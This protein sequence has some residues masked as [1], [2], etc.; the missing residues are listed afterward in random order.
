MAIGS[1]L[2]VLAAASASEGYKREKMLK[3]AAAC[4]TMRCTTFIGH[5]ANINLHR[6]RA[7]EASTTQATHQ[8]LCASKQVSGGCPRTNR[9]LAGSQRSLQCCLQDKGPAA[10][11]QGCCSASC[12]QGQEERAHGVSEQCQPSAAFT[13][14]VGPSSPSVGSFAGLTLNVAR[15]PASVSILPHGLVV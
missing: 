8:R 4:I 13:L 11:L 1:P 12:R 14:F 2:A 6:F 9:L 15:I 3:S 7:F 10:S 5:Q